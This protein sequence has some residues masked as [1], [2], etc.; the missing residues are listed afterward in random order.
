MNMVRTLLAGAFLG[1]LSS[2]F[3]L[4]AQTT[5][6]STGAVWKYLDNGSDQGTAWRAISFNDSAWTNGPAELGYGDST[7]GRPEATVISFGP[8]AN[9]KYITTYFRRSFNVA[10]P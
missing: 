9:N 4:N 2:Q 1:L 7:D 3:S 8:D 10:S 5:L 6:I